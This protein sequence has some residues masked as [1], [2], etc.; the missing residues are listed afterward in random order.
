MINI[1][2]NNKLTCF[3]FK[4]ESLKRSFHEFVVPNFEICHYIF[5]FNVLMIFMVGR[6]AFEYKK[7]PG[8]FSALHPKHIEAWLEALEM[9]VNHVHQWGKLREAQHFVSRLPQRHCQSSK[10]GKMLY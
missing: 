9:R 8:H 6:N 10:E 7:E 1:D 5:N 3:P 4:I 2:K